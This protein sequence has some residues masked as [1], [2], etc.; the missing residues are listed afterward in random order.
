LLLDRAKNFHLIELKVVKGNKVLLSPHQVSFAT[1]HKGARSWIVAKKDDTVYLYRSDQ[2]IAVFEDG[3]R[4]AAH[5]TFTK[6]I[7]WS[8]FLTTIETYRVPFEP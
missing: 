3:L 7:D 6:P 4:V 5:G 8:H 2:A 1:R